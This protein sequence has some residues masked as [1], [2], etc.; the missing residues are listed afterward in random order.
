MF[1]S[2]NPMLDRWLIERAWTNQVGRASRT[3]VVLHGGVVVGYYAL[4]SGGLDLAEAPSKFRRNMPDPIPV[5]VLGRL[6]VDQDFQGQGVGSCLLRNAVLRAQQAADIVGSHG[7]L[8]HAIDESARAFYVHY[9]FVS[10][11]AKPMTLVLAF[12]KS[13]P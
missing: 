12:A 9:G 1:A 13:S 10:S 8:V 11:P 4:A 6:A 5:A 2:G 3:Y 7:I